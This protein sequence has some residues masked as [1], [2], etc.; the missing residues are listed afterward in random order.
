MMTEAQDI[1]EYKGY[2]GS[3]KFSAD[4][5]VYFGRLLDMS[6]LVSYEANNKDNL[7]S[8]F[9]CAVDDYIKTSTRLGFEPK[10]T[11]ESR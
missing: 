4:D 11:F 6:H 5:K 1:L 2:T 10:P 7:E 3:V 8:A 9:K